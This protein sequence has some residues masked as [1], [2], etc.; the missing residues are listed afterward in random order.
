MDLS[1]IVPCY[2]EAENAERI[3]GD[4]SRALQVL[5]ALQSR[6]PLEVI[7]VDDGST[8]G[9]LLALQRAL[10]R[11][12]PFPAEVKCLAHP[13]NLGLGAALRT[14]FGAA[15]GEVVVT[16]DADGTYPF[17]EIPA[18]LALLQPG[19]DLVTASPYHPQGGVEGVPGYRQALSRGA[20]LLYQL[21]VSPKVHTYTALFRAYRGVVTRS[22]SFRANGFLGGTELLVRA[23][24]SGYNVAEYPTVLRVRRYGRSKA[25]LMRTVWAHL[26]FLAQVA[27]HRVGLRPLRVPPAPTAAARGDL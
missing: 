7:L 2:N 24:L 16:T 9:T 12:Q 8:D 4:L 17:A 6:G 22:V 3:V 10:G 19:T 25:R 1:I 5:Q 27:A 13:R 20:S 18:L 11:A 26:A 21:L 15:R 23:M 14:G